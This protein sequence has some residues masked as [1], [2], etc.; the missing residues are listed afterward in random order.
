MPASNGIVPGYPIG[1]LRLEVRYQMIVRA[2]PT[3]GAKVGGS[4]LV[5]ANHDVHAASSSSARSNQPL[6]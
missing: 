2:E 1:T 4:Q 6:K 3:T 5:F